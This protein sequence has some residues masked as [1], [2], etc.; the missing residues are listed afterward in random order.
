MEPIDIKDGLA[1]Y[2][3][4]AGDPILLFPYPH[5]YTRTRTAE[6]GLFEMLGAMGHR[7]ITFDPPGAYASSRRPDVGMPEML[8]CAAEVMKARGLSGPVPVVGHSMGGLCA[9]GL[10]LERPDLVSRLVIIDSLTGGPAVRRHRAMP[11]NWGYV[12]L[13]FWRFVWHGGK[14]GRGRGT[15]RDHKIL[16]RL[17]MNASYH[18]RGFLAAHLADIGP[19]LET[20]RDSPPPARD[21]WPVRILRLDYAKRLSE[22]QTPTLVMAGH[23][24]PQVPEAA[25]RDIASGIAGA[26]LVVFSQSGHYPYL[27][28][29]ELFKSEIKTFLA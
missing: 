1:I 17:V 13:S 27:E 18:D 20:D 16:Q 7:V 28:Q 9:L 10:A 25:A 5:G 15:L 3:I 26:R 29:P 22:I 23:Y 19:D 8:A 2:E 14:I 12:S 11:Y 24:D 6:G 4:G 21:I